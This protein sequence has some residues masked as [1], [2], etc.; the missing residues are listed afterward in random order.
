MSSF[1]IGDE[2]FVICDICG[3]PVEESNEFG[4]FCKNKCRLKEAK[5]ASKQVKAMLK[6]FLKNDE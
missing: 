6:N 3:E 1:I 5:K 2:A 4:M